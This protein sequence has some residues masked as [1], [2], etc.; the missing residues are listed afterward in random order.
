MRNGLKVALAST[1]S[2]ALLTPIK[3]PFA[4]AAP[5]I[6]ASG[7]NASICN[8]T[9]SSTGGVSASRLS[10][11]D[12]VIK[13]TSANT[14]IDWTVPNNAQSIRLLV[15]GGGGAGGVDAGPGGSGGGAYEAADVKVS[16]GALI[17][18]YV[19]AGGTAGIYNGTSASS[20]GNSNLTIG[21]TVFTGTGGSVG[22]YGISSNP[23]PAAGS[24]GFGTGVGGTS[25]SGA[26][27][28]LGKGWVSGSTG[29][30]SAGN[31]GNLLTDI[32][33]TSTRYGGGGAGGANVNGVSV[34]RVA[35]GQGG[36][37]AAGYNSPSTTVAAN[38]E[39]NSGGG[40]GAG[41]SNV[42]PNSFKSSG[43]GGSGI[44]VI[45]Y[46]PDTSAPTISNA[47]SPFSFAEN[48]NIATIAATIEISESATI[49][50]D[51]SGDYLKFSIAV[52]DTD[53]AR[54]YFL[55]SPDFE[56]RADL[57]GNNDY[58]IYLD[59]TDLA[60]NTATANFTIRVTNANETPTLGLPSISGV[61]YKGIVTSITVTT[62]A[63]GKVRF[64]AN[65]KKIANCLAV[66]TTG[67]Y[68][69]FTATCSWKPTVT[70]RHT[71][72]A[73]I[74]PTDNTYSSTTSTGAAFSVLK[75]TTLR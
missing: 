2:V 23:Q 6:T 72:K 33:G 15:L 57:D 9:V 12:C 5:N 69:N 53:T 25:T 38:G 13:F 4:S 65:G 3:I 34:S 47:A 22:P 39:A 66:P 24:A 16:P 74:T 41:M 29:A 54:I 44:I 40:G 27:G 28:G 75:R 18:T 19:G 64:V 46:T 48:T 36:G 20:G 43:A 1:L 67:S 50:L 11:G 14:T 73:T 32:T 51:A 70:S 68:P 31:N 37:G 61:V 63:A 8:Q 30:G 52:V 10:D 62:E 55:S 58:V 7:T 56:S 42:S 21:T 26:L 35:G 59:L 49:S 60:G 71:L 45:R 17:S